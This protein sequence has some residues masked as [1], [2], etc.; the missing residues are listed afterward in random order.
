VKLRHGAVLF[1]ESISPYEGVITGWN[2]WCCWYFHTR[3]LTSSAISRAEPWPAGGK[4]KPN[5]T[6]ASLWVRPVL[7]GPRQPSEG[8][9]PVPLLAATGP[10]EP[11]EASTTAIARRRV[12]GRQCRRVMPV[13]GG[14]SARNDT[15][16]TDGRVVWPCGHLLPLCAGLLTRPTGY[17]LLPR[18]AAGA[19]AQ[20]KASARSQMQQASGT[21]RRESCYSVR[22]GTRPA[23]IWNWFL[24]AG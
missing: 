3:R 10:R 4:L 2:Y 15:A 9:I 8:R 7:S 24:S 18:S 6:P 17:W 11:P 14:R 20:K 12:D 13:S 23:S 16:V 22:G 1:S 5:A 21:G 19:G